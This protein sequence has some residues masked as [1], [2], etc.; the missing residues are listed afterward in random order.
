MS[1]RTERNKSK[2]HAPGKM[3]A[4]AVALL[5]AL[6]AAANSYA[7]AFI[8]AGEGNGINVVTHPTG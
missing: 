7:G 4:G 6:C 3:I 5:G 8:F 2:S 1:H